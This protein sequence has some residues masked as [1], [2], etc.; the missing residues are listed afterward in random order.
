M[1]VTAAQSQQDFSRSMSRATARHLTKSLRDLSWFL[2]YITYAIV[3]GDPNII[4]VNVRGLREIIETVCLSGGHNC[5]NA[6]NEGSI[7]GIFQKQCRG[8]CDRWIVFRRS[9]YRIQSSHT[10]R[11]GAGSAKATTSKG[12]NCLKSTSTQ[13]SGDSN[14][15]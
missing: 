10:F 7:F 1:V 4:S 9:Y 12:C 14:S 3:A 8:K 5:G 2:R 13:P 15:S 6:G 11:Q